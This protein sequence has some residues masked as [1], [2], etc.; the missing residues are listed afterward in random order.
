VIGNGAYQVLR[1]QLVNPAKDARD[2]AEALRAAGFE[3]TVETDVKRRDLYKL[4][5]GF[6]E[7]IAATPDTVGLFYYAGHGIQTDG[8]NYLVPV[9]ANLE[10]DDE[11][12]AEAVDAGKVLRA[13][14]AAHNAVNI[15]VLDACR[16]NPLPKKARSLMR[17]LAKMDAPSGTFIA[18]AAGPGQTA[19]DGDKGSNGVFSGVLLKQLATPGLQIEEVFKRTIRGVREQTQDKQV[20]WMESSLQGNFYFF[21]V[22]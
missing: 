12:E 5:S 22:S 10:S 4:I 9:D 7:R 1:P 14:D 20:P 21:W 6:A 11:L 17:G 19:A 3:T 2:I 16:D 8:R 13:M 15:M 18:Y